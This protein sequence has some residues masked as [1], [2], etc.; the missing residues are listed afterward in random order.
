M[1]TYGRIYLGHSGS[2]YLYG[3]TSDAA[4]SVW[5]DNPITNSTVAGTVSLHATHNGSISVDNV[6]FEV[7]GTRDRR[8]P[9]LGAVHRHVGQ[10]RR[11]GREAHAPSGKLWQ[12]EIRDFVDRR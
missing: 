10:H 5:L 11:Y 6:Q 12:R 3:D 4:P 7:D 8:C 2:G 1:N 9:Y